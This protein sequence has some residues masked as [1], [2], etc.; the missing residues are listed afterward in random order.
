MVFILPE[1]VQQTCQSRF[2]IS[3]QA[4]PTAAGFLIGH[5]RSTAFQRKQAFN[6]MDKATGRQL[7][8][9]MDM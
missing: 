1:M 6:K 2:P 3:F 5:F 7:Y 8:A 4:I 9:T